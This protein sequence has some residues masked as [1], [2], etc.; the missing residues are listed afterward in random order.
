M[1]RS[2]LVT[3][4]IA[5]WWGCLCALVLSPAW[6]RAEAAP[7]TQRQGTPGP[8]ASAVWQEDAGVALRLFAGLE[9]T[10][11]Q[12]AGFQTLL[13]DSQAQTRAAEQ[14]GGPDVSTRVGHIQQETYQKALQMLNPEQRAELSL[15]VMTALVAPPPGQPTLGD[16]QLLA[17]LTARPR[18]PRVEQPGIISPFEQPGPITALTGVDDHVLAGLKAAGIEPTPLCSD[19]VFIRRVAL[20]LTGQLPTAREVLDF[21]AD[22]RP[23]KRAELVDRLMERTTFSDYQTMKWCDILRVKSEFPINLW[24]NGAATYHRWLRNAIATNMPYDELAHELLTASGSDFRTPSVN[25]YRAVEQR[26]AGSVAEAVALTFMG[27]RLRNRPDEQFK[28]ME[29]FFSRVGYK[30]TVEWK[31]EHVYWTR[32]P[33]E[34]P[35]VLLPDGTA[36]SIPFDQDPRRVFADWLTAGDNEWFAPVVCNRI[37]Y[38]LMGRGIVDPTDDFRPDNP[39]SNPALLSYLASE[40]IDSEYDLRHIYRLILNSRT[41]QQSAIAR[42]TDPRAEALFAHYVMRPVEAE[43]LQDALCT[44]FGRNIGYSSPIPEPFTYVPD[45][46]TTVSMAD[47]SISSPFLETFGRPTRDT[48]LEADRGTRVSEAQR[49]YLINS[50]ELNGWIQNTWQLQSLA[51]AMGR[52]PAATSGLLWLTLLSRYPTDVETAAA[53]EFVKASPTR[54]SIQDLVWALINSKEFFC[55]H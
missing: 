7:A 13:R 27:T 35:D 36:V 48:G 44:I 46:Q 34:N 6:N 30:M 39:P 20:D 37:W 54:E 32:E 28:L 29:V 15:R 47:G 1:H 21:L 40:L 25:F 51:P 12:K 18:P 17:L 23:G 55:K 53:A 26:D 10:E 2:H 33:L 42:S 9:L 4:G 22:Q 31:D 52:D 3:A 49:M 14:A 5:L 50:T 24:P 45:A 43:V 8:A 11:E 41:Y 16:A 38:W 19:E